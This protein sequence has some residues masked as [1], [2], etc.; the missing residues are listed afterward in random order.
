M[1][2]NAPPEGGSHPLWDRFAGYALPHYT[3]RALQLLP[4]VALGIFSI[5]FFLVY[6]M[7]LDCLLVGVNHDSTMNPHLLRAMIYGRVGLLAGLSAIVG[8][9]FLAQAFGVAAEV[10]GDLTQELL[11][12]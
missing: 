4:L 6:Q 7:L 1:S 5:M 2:P 3:R 11:E 10:A 12:E 8:F 9:F